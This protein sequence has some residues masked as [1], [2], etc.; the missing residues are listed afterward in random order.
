MIKHTFL[1]L[2]VILGA[3]CGAIDCVDKKTG[4]TKASSTLAE[5]KNNQVF[6]FKMLPNKTVFVL[7]SGLIFTI[8]NAW[9]ENRW[10]YECVNNEAILI[11]GSAPTY[12]D[13]FDNF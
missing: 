10:K 9:V 5:A 7:D 6:K 13:R 3:S 8:K 11:K 12:Y 2:T 1:I 4:M